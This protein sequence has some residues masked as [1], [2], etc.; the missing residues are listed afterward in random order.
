MTYGPVTLVTGTHQ[1]PGVSSD[2]TT[3]PDGTLHLR[4]LPIKCTD[5]T[6]DPRVSGSH[7][8][9]ANMDV[10]GTLD[11]NGAGVQWGSVRLENAGGAWEG[12]AAGV[13]SYPQRGDIFVNWYKGTGGYEGLG[14]FELWTRLCD[15]E[16]PGPDLPGRSP[17]AVDADRTTAVGECLQHSAAGPEAALTGDGAIAARNLADGRQTGRP[18]GISWCEAGF[19]VTCASRRAVRSARRR[20]HRSGRAMEAPSAPGLRRARLPHFHPVEEGAD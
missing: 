19:R 3:D 11:A 6:D 4:D 15:L 9:T 10:W 1:C 14:Y 20:R 16:D 12:R 5:K 7:I 18:G 13:A 2:W 17:D 8:A